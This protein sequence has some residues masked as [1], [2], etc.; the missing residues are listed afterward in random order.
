[1]SSDF[2]CSRCK[3]TAGG[4]DSAPIPGE[5]GEEIRQ[6]I[7]RACWAE[8]ERMEVMVINELRLNFMDPRAGTILQQHMRQFLMLEEAEDAR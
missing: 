3:R 6:H 5:I 1:M 7:C 4:F 2:Q 8:W